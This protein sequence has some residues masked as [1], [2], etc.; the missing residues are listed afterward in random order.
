MYNTEFLTKATSL[1]GKKELMQILREVD[2]FFEWTPCTF[3][4]YSEEVYKFVSERPSLT[5]SADVKQWLKM[6]DNF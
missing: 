1:Q 5:K 3:V 2:E 6:S 4:K